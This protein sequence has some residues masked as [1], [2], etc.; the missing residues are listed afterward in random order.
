MVRKI[1]RSKLETQKS[2]VY[3]DYS[4]YLSSE[5]WQKI[6]DT[7]LER[8]GKRCRVCNRAGMLNVH[9]RCY[10][11]R[12]GDESIDD[13]IT[14]CRKCHELFHGINKKKEVGQD[15]K[16]KKKG[17][18]TPGALAKVKRYLIQKGLL[19]QYGGVKLN[20]VAAILSEHKKAPMP[21]TREGY[22]DLINIYA[23]GL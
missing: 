4:E 1:V 6:R 15:R 8:D 16:A 14:L 2:R 22:R 21:T 3:L 9:H 12:W 10:S 19:S 17:N 20:V 7:V 23:K 13:L 5:V 18:L 11:E